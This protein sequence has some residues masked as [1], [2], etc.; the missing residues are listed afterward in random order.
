L[1]L[2]SAGDFNR[3][4]RQDLMARDSSGAIY[5]YFGNGADGFGDR[6]VIATGGS[7]YTIAGDGS[8]L[9]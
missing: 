1:T 9:K 7:P 4:G 5:V 3:D 8:T 2:A 6:K